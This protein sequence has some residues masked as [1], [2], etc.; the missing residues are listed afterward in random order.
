LRIGLHFAAQPS[1]L[2]S[3]MGLFA[4]FYEQTMGKMKNE[5]KKFS[6][7]RKRIIH[8]DANDVLNFKFENVVN[9]EIQMTVRIARSRL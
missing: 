3:L 6:N 9:F 5:Q 1:K 8:E 2:P 4:T 7:S